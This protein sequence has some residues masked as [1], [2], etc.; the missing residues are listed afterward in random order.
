MALSMIPNCEPDDEPTRVALRFL[1]QLRPGPDPIQHAPRL[2]LD[3]RKRLVLLWRD[4]LASTSTSTFP[5]IGIGMGIG[6][7]DDLGDDDAGTGI[8]EAEQEASSPEENGVVCGGE[9]LLEGRV[10][11]G[12]EGEL[13]EGG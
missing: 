6:V 5:G 10:E 13:S 4:S 11:E 3:M 2:F 9:V 1:P 7:R 8:E 12:E